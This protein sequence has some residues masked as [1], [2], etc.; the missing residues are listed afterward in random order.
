[1]L[2][3]FTPYYNLWKTTARW[4]KVHD[5]WMNSDWNELDAN[6]L[7]MEFESLLKTSNQVH[8]FFKGREGL[9]AIY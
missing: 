1:M 2:R 7:E 3:D 5:L 4:Y 9:D 8:R 6:D